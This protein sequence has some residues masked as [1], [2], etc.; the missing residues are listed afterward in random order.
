M[1]S[2]LFQQSVMHT[3]D[4]RKR[5]GKKFPSFTGDSRLPDGIIILIWTG[6]GVYMFEPYM[7][8]VHLL[9]LQCYISGA[10]CWDRLAS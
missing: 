2:D 8:A 5:G 3:G 10:F 6:A 7:L 4:T 9:F 1:V